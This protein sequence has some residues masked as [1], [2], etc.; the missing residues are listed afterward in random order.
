MAYYNPYMN[1]Y[2]PNFNPNYGY[3]QAQNQ[4]G[5]VPVPSEE[6]ARS[7]PIQRGASVVFRDE[8]LP[9]IYI[10][11]L[12]FGQLDL[13]TF[14]KYKLL[15]ENAQEVQ[16]SSD[17]GN[18]DNLPIY[19]TKTEFEAICEKYEALREKVEGLRKELGDE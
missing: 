8:N 19:V 11:T 16:V 14:E 1:N 15:K 7:F 10:K 6:V 4:G 3:Q 13:P 9:Y 17:K 18:D 5:L 2:N 12:G